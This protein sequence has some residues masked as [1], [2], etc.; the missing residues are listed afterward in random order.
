MTHSRVVTE[1]E[2]DRTIRTGAL[3]TM[4]HGDHARLGNYRMLLL[5]LLFILSPFQDLVTAL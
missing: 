3:K 5:E 4:E 1:T 2:G